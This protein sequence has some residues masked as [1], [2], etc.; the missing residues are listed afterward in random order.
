MFINK[1]RNIHISSFISILN[2]IKYIIGIY[3]IISST[4]SNWS[5]FQTGYHSQDVLEI[6]PAKKVILPAKKNLNYL[7]FKEL[8]LLKGPRQ[9]KLWFT[10]LD[11]FLASWLINM[12]REDLGRCI[13]FFTGHGWW[14]KHLH[15]A[16]LSDN[17]QC[18]LCEEDGC[19]E[20]PMHIFTKCIA[21]A[22]TRLALFGVRYPTREV[23]RESLCQVIE[24]ISVDTVRELIDIEQNANINSKV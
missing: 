11:H 7:W 24:F 12:Y 3:P 2:K 18:R 22:N 13:Q 8:T 19:E 15:T 21:L 10:K 17:P 4:K 14:Q 23:G 9:T 5:H 1:T 20:T 6:L 16:K